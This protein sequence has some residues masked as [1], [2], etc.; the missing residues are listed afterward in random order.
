M[1]GVRH[2]D[3]RKDSK[4]GVRLGLHHKARV[5]RVS[6]PCPCP[7]VESKYCDGCGSRLSETWVG[8]DQEDE[9]EI[10]G[11]TKGSSVLHTSDPEW[12]VVRDVCAG[13]EVDPTA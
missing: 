9:L 8:S 7:R 11:F 12:S 2:Q 3:G 10:M 4:L 5:Q 1:P 6:F 13:Q